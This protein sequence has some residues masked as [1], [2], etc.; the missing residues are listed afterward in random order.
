MIAYRICIALGLI[1]GFAA[2]LSSNKLTR[3]DSNPGYGSRRGRVADGC[4]ELPFVSYFSG[5]RRTLG[6]KPELAKSR[7]DTPVSMADSLV[8]RSEIDPLP[9]WLLTT[10]FT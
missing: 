5:V 2:A 10:S 4:F 1:N 3:A 9:R 7:W 6:F 8:A